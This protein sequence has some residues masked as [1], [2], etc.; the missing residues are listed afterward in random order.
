MLK[1]DTQRA[2]TFIDEGEL[3]AAQLQVE[4]AR[5]KVMN[6]SGEG[7]KFLGWRDLP[8]NYNR[9][10][11]AQIKEVATKI[12]QDSDILVCIGIGGSYLGARAVIDLLG[13]N[14]ST[15]VIFAGN[16][17]SSIE[18]NKIINELNGKN[19]SINVISKSGTTLEPAITFRVL[20]DKLIEKYGESASKRIYTTTDAAR[21]TL[22]DLAVEKGYERFVVPDDIGG[23]Y[24]VLT[25]VGLL[26]IAVSGVDIDELMNGALDAKNQSL[27]DAMNYAAVRNILYNKGFDVEVLSCFEPSFQQMSEWWKQLFGESEGKDGRGILPDSMIFTT[28]LHSLGQYVQ[29]GKR[30]II[31]TFVNIEK[32]PVEINIP[33]SDNNGDRLDYLVGKTLS[34]ANQKAFE[35]TVLAHNEG[36]VP[37]MSINIPEI[38]AHEIGYFI[39]FMEMSAAISAYVLGVN[40]F[41]QPGVEA[42]KKHMFRLLGRED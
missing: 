28:D 39:Y 20:R 38:N 18:L 25:A 7:N 15:K 31:E 30:Q 27:S 4:L 42:Y 3:L 13:E 22:Y 17:L 34:F 40:P 9:S 1:L 16:S 2:N 8:E 14:G 35:A 24:S 23:R 32:S 6:G 33:T 5:D 21:G 36:G 11:F 37:V 12:Q 29:D 19:W 26:P 41:N 10:E